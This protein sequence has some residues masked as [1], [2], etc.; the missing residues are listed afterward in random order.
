MRVH[1]HQLYWLPREHSAGQHH[2]LTCKGRFATTAQALA[3]PCTATTVHI[4]GIP[5]RGNPVLRKHPHA[6]YLAYC[7]TKVSELPKNHATLP[8]QLVID[9]GRPQRLCRACAAELDAPRVWTP[10]R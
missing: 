4:T 9:R 7:G 1:G 2:C 8:G 3:T 10:L 6:L 5:L